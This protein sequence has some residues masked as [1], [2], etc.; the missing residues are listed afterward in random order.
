MDVEVEY[1]APAVF[2][3]PMGIGREDGHERAG[4]QA[5]VIDNLTLS[6]CQSTQSYPNNRGL[7]NRP[8]VTIIHNGRELSDIRS[9][10][11]MPLHCMEP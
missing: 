4:L 6:L 1:G 8:L 10:S 3:L 11:T 2:P 9:K 7:W 5:F